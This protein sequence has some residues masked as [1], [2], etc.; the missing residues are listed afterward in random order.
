MHVQIA[1]VETVPTDQRRGLMDDAVAEWTRGGWRVET[2]SDFQA[3]FSKGK[4]PN[5]I[6]HL[7]LTIVTLGLWGIVWIVLALTSHEKRMIV[8]VDEFGQRHGR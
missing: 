1:H 7:L 2:R 6:L 3:V 5:H 4:R 8:S